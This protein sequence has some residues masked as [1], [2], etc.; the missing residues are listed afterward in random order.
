MTWDDSYE[1][2]IKGNV[3]TIVSYPKYAGDAGVN[4]ARALAGV[5][6]DVFPGDSH[7]QEERV[8]CEGRACNRSL[9]LPFVCVT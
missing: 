5:T 3:G 8:L 4:M 9:V 7:K 2:V 1:E 6:W